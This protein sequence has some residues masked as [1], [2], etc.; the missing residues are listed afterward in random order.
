[1]LKNARPSEYFIGAILRAYD[2]EQQR[3]QRAVTCSA[4]WDHIVIE[5]LRTRGGFDAMFAWDQSK[6]R[7]INRIGTITEAIQRGFVPGLA[8]DR[9]ARG[10]ETVSAAAEPRCRI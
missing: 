1:M 5:C 10:R 2:R 7:S 6:A 3:G 9:D 4:L 8:L